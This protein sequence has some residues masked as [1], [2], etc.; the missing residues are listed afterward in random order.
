MRHLLAG[1]IVLA[2]AWACAPAGPPKP[3]ALAELPDI[4][5]E[6]LLGDIKTLSADAYGGR[7][8]GSPGEALTVTYLSQQFRAA[9]IEPAAADGTYVQKVPLVSITPTTVSPLV[10]AKAG[11][12]RSFKVKDEVVGFSPRVT[13][14]AAIRDSEL[15][16][17]GYGVQAPELAW[18]DYRGIDV[19]GKTLV[20]L[21]NDPPVPDVANPTALDPKVFGGRAMTYYGRWTYKYEKAAELGAAAV[22]IVHETEPAGYP[23]SVV[24][25]FGGER[26]DLVTPDKNMTQPA[27]QGWLSLDAAKA[28]LKMAGQDY[29]ALKAQARTRTFTPVALGLRASMS[30]A[31]A[32]KTLESANVVGKITGSDVVLK[33]EAVVYT[34]HWDH[35]GVADPVDGDTIYNGAL[36]NASGTALL[37]ELARAFKRVTPAPKR[38]IIFAAVTA[39]ESGLLGSEFY[40]RSPA[41][42]L[43]KTLA[44][45]NIDGINIW[46]R[47]KD[48]S[49]IG[50][51]ASALDDYARE[52]AAEQGRVL[53][54]DAEPEKGFYYRSDHF[55]F[56]KMGVPAFFPDAGVDFIGQPPTYGQ[57]KRDEYTNRFYHQPSDDV[58]SWWNLAGAAEDGK[59][60]FAMGYRVA[61]AATY[62][63]WAPGN[64][65]RSIRE[66]Q[67]R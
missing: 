25:G 22:F 58:K 26:F 38:T 24:Q 62:P 57:E 64:E 56:A 23:F 3:L 12:S 1:S 45:I 65:F 4:N 5:A 49:V 34:A 44:N 6:T 2:L 46:G 39:E 47:T 8:P 31:Q 63:E 19:N 53:R 13:E 35:L 28:L 61:N 52:A 21:V 43:A 10:V 7:A 60:L 15:V 40:A 37:L 66:R 51:G 59:L 20:V 30:I 41:I 33:N 54:P 11:A 67:L 9:G 32:T 55:N 14:A 50:L 18:D 36:D 16:F 48:L 17:V 42:P 29:D 27:V